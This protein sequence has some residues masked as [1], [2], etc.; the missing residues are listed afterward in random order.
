[1]KD[2][3]FL[4]IPDT[5]YDQ[6]SRD[7]DRVKAELKQWMPR[8]ELCHDHTGVPGQRLEVRVSITKMALRY[9]YDPAYLCLHAG[10]QA[11][12]ELLCAWKGSP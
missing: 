12:R 6:L 11:A 7:Y 5:R 1:M 8:V 4:V 10:K 3:Q 9:A 2:E